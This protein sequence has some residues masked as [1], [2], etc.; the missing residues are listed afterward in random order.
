[1]STRDQWLVKQRMTVSRNDHILLF[2]EVLETLL[3]SC[4]IVRFC[5]L[6]HTLLHMADHP[7]TMCDAYE[8]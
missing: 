8:Q 1:M 7:K 3:T 5:H 4:I 6:S 2:S